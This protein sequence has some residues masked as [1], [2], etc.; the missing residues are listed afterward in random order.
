MRLL[1]NG[2]DGAC[3]TVRDGLVAEV[4]ARTI[5]LRAAVRTSRRKRHEPHEKGR[6]VRFI[7]EDT[8]NETGTNKYCSML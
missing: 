8:W 4:R 6:E 1:R 2:L 3:S 7:S 5:G